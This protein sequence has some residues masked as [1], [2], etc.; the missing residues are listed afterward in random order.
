[1]QQKSLYTET[2]S[3]KFLVKIIVG[4]FFLSFG[5]IFLVIG[6]QYSIDSEK[7]T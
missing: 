1:M 5:F 7:L 3:D 4:N 6:L 2:F